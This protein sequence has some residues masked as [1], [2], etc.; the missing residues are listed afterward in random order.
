MSSRNDLDGAAANPGAI[1]Q[2]QECARAILRA[3]RPPLTPGAVAPP[4]VLGLVWRGAWPGG[5]E[6]PVEGAVFRVVQSQLGPG[7]ACRPDVDRGGEAPP[8]PAHGAPRV[9]LWSERL[10]YTSGR[11]RGYHGG[12]SLQEAVV[13]L[14]VLSARPAP[15]E[16][17]TAPKPSELSWWPLPAQEADPRLN[18]AGLVASTMETPPLS[19]RILEGLPL[20]GGR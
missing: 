19:D 6:L 8:D 2:V 7:P 12:V 10:R 1:R 18:G 15:P 17:W 3:R 20:F 14:A 16:G 4:V 11:R 5:E 13:P 9:A